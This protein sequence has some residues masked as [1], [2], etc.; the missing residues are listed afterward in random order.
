[1]REKTPEE[2][3][4]IDSLYFKNRFLKNLNANETVMNIYN[5]FR[6]I[7]SPVYRLLSPLMFMLVPFIYLRLFTGIK[8]PFSTY[9]KLFKLTLFGGIPDPVDMIRTTQNA[10]NSRNPE[11]IRNLLG[12][13]SRRGGIKVSKLASMLFSLILYIQNVINSFEISG[14]TKR[15]Y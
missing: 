9:L 13:G 10:Y 11:M 3:H 6:I 4:I 15:N 5:F 2:R 8:I 12:G 7:F 14:R 1:M